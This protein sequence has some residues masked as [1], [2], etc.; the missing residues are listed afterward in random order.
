MLQFQPQQMRQLTAASLG[1]FVTELALHLRAFS[2]AHV[3]SLDPAVL[4]QVIDFG[5]ARAEHH[6]FSLRGPIRFYVEMMFMLGSHFDT[7]PQYREL[8]G[9][10]HRRDDSSEMERADELHRRLMHY[11]E[12]TGGPRHVFEALALERALGVRDDSVGAFADRPP[13]ALV[14]V[15]QAIHPEKVE[16][17]GR[18]AVLELVQQA[19]AA[20][21]QR[22]PA[23]HGAGPLFAGLMFTLG[24]GCLVDPQYGWIAQGLGGYGATAADAPQR[25][26]RT[27]MAFLFKCRSNLGGR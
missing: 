22:N 13:Q 14:E 23:W 8:L 10:L 6:G 9:P 15:L 24:H 25:L 12:A 4:R 2:P 7:D 27:F 26:F 21:L 18:A 19:F 17:I 11:A 1:N 5:T 16:C 20:A 3:A